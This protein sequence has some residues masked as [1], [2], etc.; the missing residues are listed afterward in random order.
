M[1]AQQVKANGQVVAQLNLRQ[2]K[3]ENKMDEDTESVSVLYDEDHDFQ[4]LFVE[5]KTTMKPT[6]SKTKKPMLNFENKLVVTRLLV[7]KLPC[8]GKTFPRYSSYV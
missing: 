8:L 6:S 2:F 4:K 5:H 7:T 3:H 1:I